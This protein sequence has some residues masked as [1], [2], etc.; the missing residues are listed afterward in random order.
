MYHTRGYNWASITNNALL[1]DKM[2]RILNKKESRQ[3]ILDTLKPIDELVKTTYGPYGDSVLISNQYEQVYTKD[4]LSVISAVSSEDI[5]ENNIIKDFIGLVKYINDINKDG[6]TSTSIITY[7]LI[8][9]FNKDFGYPPFKI[10]E[11]VEKESKRIQAIIDENGSSVEKEDIFNMLSV[12]LN[13]DEN[14]LRLM[15]KNIEGNYTYE[16]NKSEDNQY[17]IA[18]YRG[19]KTNATSLIQS[20]TA[21]IRTSQSQNPNVGFKSLIIYVKEFSDYNALYR[22]L[23]KIVPLIKDSEEYKKGGLPCTVIMKRVK[24]S[25]DDLIVFAAGFYRDFG[26]NLNIYS[27][28]LPPK[29]IQEFHNSTLISH[30]AIGNITFTENAIYIGDNTHYVLSLPSLSD[31]EFK[32]KRDAIDDAFSIVGAKK[33]VVG[34]GFIYNKIIETLDKETRDSDIEREVKKLIQQALLEPIK[35]LSEK[36]GIELDSLLHLYKSN[37][38]YNFASN[39]EEEITET[40]VKELADSLKVMFEFSLK[41]L[42]NF[43]TTGSIIQQ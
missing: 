33:Y 8:K 34:G 18:E 4:G 21:E 17:S 12:V 9:H 3:L 23:K 31:A 42:S 26:I 7:S 28:L 20:V 16:V 22:E 27:A 15:P 30:L 37:K 25:K 43:I 40:S 41:Y 11:F 2:S 36:S 6:S 32:Q 19:Y 14:L 1:N 38:I 10:A 13:N 39:K 35:I 24:G 29:G 5:I